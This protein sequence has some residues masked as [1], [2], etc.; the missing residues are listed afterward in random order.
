MLP[1]DYK[2]LWTDTTPQT[3]YPD[4]EGEVV[5]DVVIVG[6][7]FA[8]IAAGYYLIKAGLKV[9]IIEAE[10]IVAGTSGNTTAKITSLHDLKYAFLK[11]KFS[12]EKARQYGESN[13]WAIAEIE[14]IIREENIEADFYRVPSLVYARSEAGASQVEEEAKAAKSLGLPA[15]F[16]K[17]DPA[18][19][20]RIFGAVKFENQAYFHP[21]K[22]LLKLA[23]VLINNGSSIFEK[24]R[25]IEIKEGEGSEAH[26][27]RTEKGMVKAKQVIIATNFPIYDKAAFFL[28]M[29]QKRSYA[30]A[31]KLNGRCPEGMYIGIDEDLTFRPHKIG[32][33]EWLI[34]GGGDHIPGTDKKNIDRFGDLEK[35]ARERF[36]IKSI[37]YKWAAQDS[38]PADQ[39]PFI[40]K[41]PLSERIYV[42]TGYGEWGMTTSI[43]SA[44]LLT[45]LITEKDNPLEGLYS[46]TRIK[47]L[48]SVG[49]M[50]EM[51]P[52]ILKGFGDYVRKMEGLDAE[53][54]N[55][56]EGRVVSYE[57]KKV[58]VYKDSGGKMHARSAV[59]THMG[60]IVDWNSTEKSWDCPCHG[61][62]FTP[63]G[64]IL[65]GPARKPL[66]KMEIK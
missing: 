37:D 44:K 47:P 52:N 59:C 30:L 40:G 51:I 3:N 11:K 8:G 22:F 5:A 32:N 57:G 26:E 1:K 19:P 54:L 15:S 2:S 35:L 12:E 66:P 43:V 61:S 27:V 23:E 48:V 7:G 24:S 38:S 50:K 60:C 31:V 41:M 14:R 64:E 55:N 33:E 29:E 10:R 58:A 6:G 28:R 34:I 49:K 25:V 65:N 13:Q 63:D 42:T 17:E 16:I 62:R 46:P 56:E 4:L 45:D 21:R 53:K 39:V 20:F 18:V 36:D 9:V